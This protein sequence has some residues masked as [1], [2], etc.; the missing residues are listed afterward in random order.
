MSGA[1][2]ARRPVVWRPI[3]SAQAAA[4]KWAYPEKSGMM[5]KHFVTETHMIQILELFLSSIFWLFQNMEMIE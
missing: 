5:R 4:P 2:T 1:Q 3:G